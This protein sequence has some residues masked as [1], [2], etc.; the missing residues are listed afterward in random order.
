MEEN[1][2]LH[3]R[4]WWGFRSINFLSDDYLYEDLI[5]QIFLRL[6]VKSLLRFR[7]ISKSIYHMIE[8]PNF[9]RMHTFQSRKRVIFR[10][11]HLDELV[12]KD[13]E[14]FFTSH[15]EDEL[16]LDGSLSKYTGIPVL[17]FPVSGF[18]I[19][20]VGSC[21]GILCLFGSRTGIS[22]WNP[23][24]KRKLTLPYY[25]SWLDTNKSCKTAVGFGYEQITHDYK[26]LTITSPVSR[27]DTQSRH[28][29]LVYS[30]NL[31]SWNE[32]A[33]PR[34]CF[35]HVISRACFIH[36][37]L[38][39]VVKHY[40][41][42]SDKTGH[43]FILTFDLST[44]VFGKILLPEPNYETRHLAIINGSLAVIST[45]NELNLIRVN[46]RVQ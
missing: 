26:V 24:I 7:S 11:R 27:Q 35:T 17:K 40:Q 43:L 19:D 31:G 4:S 42:Q 46:E 5:S 3:E 36:G 12:E 37:A 6:P 9:I 23:S 39:W 15:S 20:I 34:T 25:P 22:L 38:H 14:D 32:I 29:I 2:S 18:D 21:N 44:R 1:L 13:F 41:D 8:N 33:P 45:Q 10:H 16:P 30:T 28:S